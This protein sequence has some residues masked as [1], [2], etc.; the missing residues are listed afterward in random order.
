[1]IWR[2]ALVGMAATGKSTVA[3]EIAKRLKIRA[4]IASDLLR[5]LAKK[6]GFGGNNINWFGTPEGFALLDMRK[7]NFKIDEDLDN[8]LI[9][10]LDEGN[11]IMTTRTMPCLYKNHPLI[12][13]YLKASLKVRTKRISVRDG[14]SLK[15]AGE[16]IQ[17]RDSDYD[18]Y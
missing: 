15:Q 12:S 17:K 2:V 13:I 7:K 6:E 5:K 1:M 3:N 8:L 9:E 10:I 11:V 14:I 4:V 16:F 18:L